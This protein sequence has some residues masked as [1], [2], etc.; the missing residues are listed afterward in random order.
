[1]PTANEGGN[2][3][4]MVVAA[5]VDADA[6]AA[7]M[8]SCGASTTAPLQTD[9][10]SP[11]PLMVNPSVVNPRSFR[12]SLTHG[13]L[14]LPGRGMTHVIAKCHTAQ[15][16]H[17]RMLPVAITN[18][19]PSRTASWMAAMVAGASL[20]ALFSRVPSTSVKN[21]DQGDYER[22]AEE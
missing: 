2:G 11:G 6:D 3:G 9:R 16:T 14:A 19:M 8:L 18:V 20:C 5:I 7:G 21:R 15:R 13:P 17:R 12:N 10:F 22:S 1:M 4:V